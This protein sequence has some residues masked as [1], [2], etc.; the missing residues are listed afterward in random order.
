PFKIGEIKPDIEFS[1]EFHQD[2]NK[3]RYT[4]LINAFTLNIMQERLDYF[5]NNDYSL[6]YSKIDNL[7]PNFTQIELERLKTYKLDQKSILSTIVKDIN[8][9]NY[10]LYD[11]IR[12][13][14]NFFTKMKI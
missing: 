14:W 2:L 3:F 13:V 8:L 6:I 4:L 12:S 5:E 9:S 7:F 11:K 10:K 1:L